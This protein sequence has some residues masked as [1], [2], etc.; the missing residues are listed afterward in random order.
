MIARRPPV[1][2]HALARSILSGSRFRIAAA[3][4]RRSAMEMFLDWLRGVW[5]RMWDAL[6]SHVHVGKAASTA[7]GY[8]IAIAL[9]ALVLV[10]IARLVFGSIRDVRRSDAR[11]LEQPLDPHELYLRGRAAAAR[12]DYQAALALLFRATLV[13]LQASEIVRDDP[14]RTVNQWRRAVAGAQPNLAP[15]FDAIARPFVAAV[16]A[17]IPARREQWLEAENAYAGLPDRRDRA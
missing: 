4:S 10:M 1:D 2:P 9:I 5:S 15:A 6:F 16:Y 13:K 17:E 8:T 11:P 3:S 12:G 14:S 7:I